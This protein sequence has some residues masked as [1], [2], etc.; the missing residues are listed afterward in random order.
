M[1]ALT[2]SLKDMRER[3]GKMV[4]GSSKSGGNVTFTILQIWS[5][6]VDSSGEAQLERPL[7]WHSFCFLLCVQ[8][9][10]SQPMTWEW[11]VP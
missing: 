9:K 8:G 10:L 3:L 2:T 7:A 5:R 4:I 1:L 11:G 6:D